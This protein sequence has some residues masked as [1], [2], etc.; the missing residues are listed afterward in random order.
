MKKTTTGL[1]IAGGG[2]STYA[3]YDAFA[4]AKA[5]GS[6]FALNSIVYILDNDRLITVVAT[7][8]GVVESTDWDWIGGANQ[9]IGGTS[10]TAIATPAMELMILFRV[11]EK[12]AA[13]PPGR[14]RSAGRPQRPRSPHRR[15]AW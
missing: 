13:A 4:A 10:A 9:P 5:G 14:T 7:G 11:Y 15:C 12:A 1:A 8:T 6:Y 2:I 3:D